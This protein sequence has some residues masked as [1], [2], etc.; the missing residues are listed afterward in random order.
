LFEAH[1]KIFDDLAVLCYHDRI[2][3]RN[4]YIR[5]CTIMKKLVLGIAVCYGVSS[6][7][8]MASKALEQVCFYN[9]VSSLSY[10]KLDSS[11]FQYAIEQLSSSI[12][13]ARSN[14]TD[15]QAYFYAYH[16]FIENQGLLGN[17]TQLSE[18]QRRCVD[19][20]LTH[21]G[22]VT[23]T[24]YSYLQK[25]GVDVEDLKKDI[26]SVSSLSANLG[27]SLADADKVLSSAIDEMN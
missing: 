23:Q 5:R 27:D 16:K 14:N 2:V 8:G 26:G 10:G 13:L 19:T 7:N 22:D 15:L 3:F 1:I 18:K 9:A 21:I 12:S 20:I 4:S 24:A 25:E 11:L 17:I 6:V